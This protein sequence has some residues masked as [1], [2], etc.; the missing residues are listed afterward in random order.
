MIKFCPFITSMGR[1][2]EIKKAIL[3]NDYLILGGDLNAKLCP[4]LDKKYP[5]ERPTNKYQGYSDFLHNLEIKNP[6]D[7]KSQEARLDSFLVPESLESNS[8]V[9]ILDFDINVSCDHKA[10][11]YQDNISLVPETNLEPPTPPNFQ[12]SFRVKVTT[13]LASEKDIKSKINKLK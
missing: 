6:S 9:E 12:P 7:P 10:I 5:S 11:L 4:E 3:K 8:K 2:L 1:P 13:N